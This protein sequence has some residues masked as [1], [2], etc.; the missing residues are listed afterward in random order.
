LDSPGTPDLGP[1]PHTA[2]TVATSTSR[3][4]DLT[5]PPLV[6]DQSLWTDPRHYGATQKLAAAARAAEPPL[7]LLRYCSVR[8]PRPGYCA[9]LFDPAVFRSNSPLHRETWF[10]AASRERVR[11]MRDLP[12]AELAAFE[13]QYERA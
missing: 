10:I 7:Q 2:F 3:S 4:L 12:G 6:R 8:D 13:F 5:R 1:V 11:C 9:V